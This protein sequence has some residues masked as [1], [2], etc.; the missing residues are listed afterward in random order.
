[1]LD[2]VG[3]GGA[4]DAAEYGDSG[5]NTLKGVAS[6]C[7]LS[8]PN[9]ERLG[10]GLT[11][12]FEGIKPVSAPAGAVGVMIEKSKGKDTVTGHWE[13][14][15]LL[16]EEPFP[17]F[18]EGFPDEVMEEFVSRTG[19]GYLWN[20]P[21]SGTEIIA[22][23][24]E[25][26][27]RTGKPIIYTS[28][29]S[30]FQVAA[31]VEVIPLEELYRIC[32]VAREVVDPLRVLRVIARPFAGNPGNFYRT[33]DRKDFPF[34]PPCETALDLLA[35]AG[36]E[37]VS[38]GKVSEMF[39]GR[40]FSRTVKTGN[41]METVGAVLEEM[42]EEGRKF[43]FA[44]LN[45][46]DTLFGHRNDVVGFA[47][48]LEEFDDFVPSI[49]DEMDQEDLLIITADHGNDP[50]Y[51]GTDHTRE[52]VPLIVYGKGVRGGCFGEVEGFSVVGRLVLER[53][54]VDVPFDA[55]DFPLEVAG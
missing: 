44:N 50:T 37:V 55:A 29:D 25:E 48:A 31:H 10:L 4:P 42:R 43:V 47:R 24:G 36:V 35:D 15:G 45:D 32:R 8:L 2:G 21:A 6:K 33:A 46:F 23:L 30:V 7:A 22:R 28:A 54:G 53:F 38:V 3:I 14:M 40:G 39:G 13:M 11:G 1:M 17:V 19:Y 34:P 51:P 9:L 49:I 27:L 52:K 16:V 12:T 20:R 18:P 41:N 26:H 5:A